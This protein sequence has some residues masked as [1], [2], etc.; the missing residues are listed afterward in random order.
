MWRHA[1]DPTHV[2]DDVPMGARHEKCRALD[3]NFLAS[4]R[5]DPILSGGLLANQQQR[6][7]ATSGYP[8]ADR[9]RQLDLATSGSC[10]D[11]K[12][13]GDRTPRHDF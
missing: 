10:R 13:R 5:V 6:V 2:M 8:P 12:A 3:E 7:I 4:R 9:T 11:E 1:A